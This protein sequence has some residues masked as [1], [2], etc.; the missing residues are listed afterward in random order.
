MQFISD[1]SSSTK[2]FE[3]LEEKLSPNASWKSLKIRGIF[4]RADAKN[5][6]G[7]IY[8]YAVLEKALSE[9]SGSLNSRNMVGELDHP[10]DSSPTVSL[11]NVSHVITGLKFSGKD[12]IGEAVILDDPGPAG[13]P[14]GRIL[15]SLIRNDLTVGISSRGLGAV[16]KN[17]SGE[18]VVSEYRVI[19]WDAVQDPSTQ[20]AYISP[21]LEAR[22][23]LQRELRDV[24]DHDKN[25]KELQEYF[26]SLRSKQ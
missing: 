1:W 5:H 9:V 6:N 3:L 18:D 26:K 11:K 17:R 8:P 10:A 12:L 4:Q 22:N 7:R 19:T 23:K 25:V 24:L 20:G 14:M 16:E 2:G 15:G 13:T 21:M